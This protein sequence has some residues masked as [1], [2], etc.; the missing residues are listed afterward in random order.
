MHDLGI[1]LASHWH[2]LGTALAHIRYVHKRYI[3]IEDAG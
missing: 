2:R 1:A 3:V